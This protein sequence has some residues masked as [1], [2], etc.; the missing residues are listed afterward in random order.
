MVNANSIEYNVTQIKNGMMKHVN[1]CKKADVQK[2]YSWNPNTYILENS[3][4]LFDEITY[5]MD[6]VPTDVLS[7]SDDKK[8]RYKMYY[9][10]LQT[11]LLMI[12]YS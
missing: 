6:I 5:V 3:K 11:V 4:H 12:Y 10:I 2:G 9:Y 1:M 8:V 7:Y